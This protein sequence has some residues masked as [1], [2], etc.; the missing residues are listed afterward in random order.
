[1]M[2]DMP[3]GVYTKWEAREDIRLFN[4]QKTRKISWNVLFRTIFRSRAHNVL[5]SL[6]SLEHHKNEL[7]HF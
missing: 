1:M 4:P 2:K 3:T 7:V 5:F 6:N